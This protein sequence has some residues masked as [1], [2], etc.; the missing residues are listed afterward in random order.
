MVQRLLDEGGEE[1]NA[2][3]RVYLVTISRVVA[4]RLEDGRPYKDLTTMSRMDIGLAIRDAFDKPLP[5]GPRGGRPRAG[6]HDGVDQASLLSFVVVFREHHADGSVHF[7][8]VVKLTKNFRFG[9]A[10]HALRIRHCLPSHWS[11]T[12]TQVWSAMRYLYIGTHAKPDVD[13]S[14]WQWTLDGRELDLFAL[15]Q[16]PFEANLWRK[17][18]EV[19]DKSSAQATK[20]AKTSKAFSKLDMTALVISKNLRTKDSLM[21]YVQQHGTIAM[22]AYVNKNQRRLSMDIEDAM[23]WEA[24]PANADLERVSDWDMVRECSTKECPQETGACSYKIAVGEI[25]ARNSDSVD[26]HELAAALRDIL[27]HG[28]TKTTRVPFL[29][30]P[31]NSGK[32]TIVYPFDDLFTRPRVLHKPALGSSFGLRNLAGHNK[33]FIL[34][35][36]FRP[37][38]FAHEKTVPVSLFLSLFIG[39]STEIQ[40]SQAFNDG[41]KDIV[42]KRGAVFTAK[43]LDLWEPTSRVPAED[44]RHMR[45]RVQEFVFTHSFPDSSLKEVTPCAVCMAKWIVDGAMAWDGASNFLE[46]PVQPASTSAS[47]FAGPSDTIMGCA[48]L[49]EALQAPDSVNAAIVDDLEQLGAVSV[50]EL[51]VPDWA[52][53]SVWPALKPLQKRRLLQHLGL[54]SHS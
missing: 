30:G 8:A 50:H 45:K 17:R 27:A 7:H 1:A 31:T 49:L 47:S 38:E 20:A 21:A 33:R 36:D 35:D 15:S 52:A 34:W 16:Q 40:V 26:R 10:K 12:H 22:Q 42:W 51:T 44:V 37:V 4:A 19:S 48:G 18:R 46:L 2:S 14:P 23:E 9:S 5:T 25:F 43:Q 6:A 24:A 41:N 39:Q 11:C 29:V 53:L 28:P 13:E 3:Q 32:S 54:S